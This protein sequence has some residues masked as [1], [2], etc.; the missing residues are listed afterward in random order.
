MLLPIIWQLKMLIAVL[1]IL[2]EIASDSQSP[3]ELR[4]SAAEI[5]DCMAGAYGKTAALIA[6][7]SISG[8]EFA[9]NKA[10][11]YAWDSVLACIPGGTAIS[12][13]AKTGRMLVNY[14]FKT[15]TVIQ[16]YYQLEAAVNIEDAIIELC[17]IRKMLIQVIL[18]SILLFI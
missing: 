6:E 1:Q 10:I 15:E 17:R 2:N 13:G 8:I 12:F 14:F 11:N 9:L 5:S 3:I 7:G 18:I 4:Y 16:G